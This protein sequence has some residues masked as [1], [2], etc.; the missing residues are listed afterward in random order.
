LQGR[1][2]KERREREKKEEKSFHLRNAVSSITS[3]EKKGE[4]T[5][6]EKERR[7]SVASSWG[8]GK[9]EIYCG[10]KDPPS[11]AKNVKKEEG[12]ERGKEPIE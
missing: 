6:K 7:V 2:R 5:G 9:S 3:R 4:A 10:R 11:A 8:K 1:K 12:L